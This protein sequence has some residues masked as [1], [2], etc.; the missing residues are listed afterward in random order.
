MPKQHRL[1]DLTVKAAKIKTSS[2]FLSD[3]GG[4]YLRITPAGRRSWVLRKMQGGK[5]V[6]RTLG[7]YPDMS[8]SAARQSVALMVKDIDEGVTDIG[9]GITL[10]HAFEE[11]LKSRNLRGS[12]ISAYESRFKVLSAIADQPLI[13]ITPQRLRS[14]MAPLVSAGQIPTAKSALQ[15]VTS[16][17]RHALAWGFIE[18]PRLQFV[19]DVLPANEVVHRRSITP[20]QL[21]ELFRDISQTEIPAHIQERAPYM[22]LLFYTL[23]RSNEAA[24]LQWDFIDSSERCICMPA[25]VM[26]M[27]VAHRVPITE[28][29][30]TVLDALRQQSPFPNSPFVFPS[31]RR[32]DAHCGKNTFWHV[33]RGLGILPR[34]SPHGVRSLA[35]SYFAE[36]NADFAAAEMCLAHRIENQMQRSYQ[37]Y[38]YLEQRRTLMAEWCDYVNACARPYL[39]NFPL[40]FD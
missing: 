6:T 19:S 22:A 16:A 36:H 24:N 25:S 9:A 40:S 27:G 29:L 3:G 8:L 11:W 1:T 39:P 5:T 26:K 15:L 33:F 38:D 17:E 4:L 30:Q 35:R 28:P 14:V 13:T 23:L 10:R 32:A 34:I 18:T 31:F 2:Y 12:S 7:E 37:R 20:E 21:P